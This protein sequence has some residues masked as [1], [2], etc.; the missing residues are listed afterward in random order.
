MYDR[1]GKE[2]YLFYLHKCTNSQRICII[3]SILR[4]NM[5]NYFLVF[6]TLNI[7]IPFSCIFMIN[8]KYDD[9][10]CLQS[11]YISSAQQINYI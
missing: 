1:G 9:T 2:I 8:M 3:V 4:S 7:C 11:N 5:L 6:T 10:G